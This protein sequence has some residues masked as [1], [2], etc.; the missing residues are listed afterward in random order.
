MSKSGIVVVK[1]DPVRGCSCPPSRNVVDRFH[2]LVAQSGWTW[3]SAR[4][5]SRFSCLSKKTDE[6]KDTP[7]PW[8]CGPDRCA[9]SLANG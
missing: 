7:T 2:A 8:P 9:I 6:K 1:T 3:R 4:R 5:A